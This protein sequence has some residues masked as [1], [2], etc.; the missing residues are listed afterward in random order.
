MRN[1]SI[2]LAV[3]GSL[4]WLAVQG[5]G[6]LRGGMVLQPRERAGS[7]GPT[8]LQ[9]QPC[10]VHS[11][12]LFERQDGEQGVAGACQPEHALYHALSQPAEQPQVG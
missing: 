9:G 12:V 11:N 3:S 10:A 2:N 4:S 5:E 1:E 8:E 6:S 7:A